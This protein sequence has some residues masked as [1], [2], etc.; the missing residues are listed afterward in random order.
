M[1][2]KK[3]GGKKSRNPAKAKPPGEAKKPAGRRPKRPS[4][5]LVDCAWM[6][7]MSKEL[8]VRI[9]AILC[10][11]VASPKEVSDELNVSLSQ[12]SYHVS[13]LRKGRLIVEDHKVPRRG[14]VEHFYK[15]LAPT[16]IPPN[17][18]DHLPPAVRKAISLGILQGFFEDAASSLEAG[19]FDAAPGELSLTPLILDALGIEGLGRLARGFLES[20]LELQADAS[21]RLASPNGKRVKPTSATVF[22]ASFLSARSPGEGKRAS[23]TKRR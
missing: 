16:L 3:P 13:V 11:R 5:E 19:V 18:W 20:V 15:A 14:A 23:A 22:L 21:K 2:R 10:E 6:K 9:F 1:A 17:A 12:A 4:D 7:A 8:R